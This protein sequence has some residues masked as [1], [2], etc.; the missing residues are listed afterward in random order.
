M[1]TGFHVLLSSLS[2]F[3]GETALPDPRTIPALET[4]YR[5]L[6]KSSQRQQ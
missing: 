1:R 3:V 4:P 5:R 2:N 6:H